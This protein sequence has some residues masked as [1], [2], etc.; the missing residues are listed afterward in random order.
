MGPLA[1]AF[2]EIDKVLHRLRRFLLE[3][4]ANDRSLAGAKRRVSAGL[5]G[6]ENPFRC[7]SL[8]VILSEVKDLLFR[9]PLLHQTLSPRAIS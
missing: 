6:H 4:A 5:T 1:F 7:L 3:Q 8:F 9:I 2:G